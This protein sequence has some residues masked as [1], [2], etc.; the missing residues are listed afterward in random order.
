MIVA[1]ALTAERCCGKKPGLRRLAR[2]LTMRSEREVIADRARAV[3][4]ICPPP[5]P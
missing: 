3:R 5:S 1:A 4:R 2:I